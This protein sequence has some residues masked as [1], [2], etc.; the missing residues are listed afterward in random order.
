LTRIL[1]IAYF[2][3]PLG[4][5]AVQ[6]PLKTIKYLKKAGFSVDVLT[7][8]DIQYHSYDPALLSESQAD[9]IYRTKSYDPMSLFRKLPIKKETSSNI[10]FNTPERLKRFFRNLFIIDD[11]IGWMP[12]AYKKALALIKENQYHAIIATVGPL[13][14][15]I[16][17]H[18]LH[19]KT[20]IPFFVDYR[21]LMTIRKYSIYLTKLQKAISENYE[22]KMLLAATGV[23]F[24]GNTMKEIM[25]KHFG[26]FL[27]TKSAVVFN[28]YDDCDFPDAP[29]KQ[30]TSITYIRYIGN[31][32]ASR[33]FET[34][35]A[36]LQD[37]QAANELPPNVQFEFVGNYY[38]ETQKVLKCEALQHCLKEIPQ[39][40]HA[41]A[42]RLMQTADLLL[43]FIN[44]K[45]GAEYI[46]GKLFEYIKTQRPILAMVPPDSE[47]ATILRN[48]GH[49]YIC[50]LEDKEKIKEYLKDF[51]AT[52]NS[53]VYYCNEQFSR[54]NQTKTIID[55]LQKTIYP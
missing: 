37:L 3:P 6:R 19:K 27:A 5:P 24:V 4:G 52:Q 33:N 39:Q 2:Y 28:G 32:Y 14:S 36:A 49:T 51:W 42:V 43:L 9:N 54:E 44:A 26:E 53:R 20:K 48:L 17:A 30:E 25:Q 15:G 22:K 47:P 1:F 34:F 21:D 40:P 41:E 11:K 10:Y 13:T 29:E 8:D 38:L 50:E 18:R 35:I 31:V 23:F 12:R 7:V 16:L 55:M 45:E 46:T